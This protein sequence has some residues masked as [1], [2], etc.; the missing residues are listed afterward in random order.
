[1]A[2][3]VFMLD[4]RRS[5]TRGL[6]A[7]PGDAQETTTLLDGSSPQVRWICS[8]VPSAGAAFASPGTSTSGDAAA[9]R[10]VA[11]APLKNSR[12]ET[13]TGGDSAS[14]ACVAG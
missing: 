10:P 9:A 4:E 1:M 8:G 13:P 7:W 12:R 6:T 2:W 3:M 11:P 14:S 5:A